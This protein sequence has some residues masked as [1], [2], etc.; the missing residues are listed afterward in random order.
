[1]NNV[2][3]WNSFP[4]KERN[5]G[6][7]TYLYNLSHGLSSL[8]NNNEINVVFLS[9]ILSDKSES[10][11][12]KKSINLFK[13]FLPKILSNNLRILNYLTQLRKFK[14]ELSV[15]QINKFK[16]IHFHQSIDIYKNR[17]ILK[18]FKGKVFLTSHSPKPAWMETIEDIYNLPL[19]KTFPTLRIILE[20]M[21]IWGFKKAD[22]LIFPCSEAIEPYLNWERYK[23]EIHILSKYKYLQTGIPK[24]SFKRDRVSIRKELNIPEN[25]I[26][27]S[28]IGRHSAIKGYDLLLELGK[29]ILKT[30]PNV[31]FLIAG[32]EEPI[33]GL[34]HK[35]WIEVGWTDDPHSYV[36]ASDVFILPNR[37]TYFDLV[38][39]EILSI[40]K[41]I[42]LS[43]TGGNKH[44]NKYLNSGIFFFEN[45]NLGSLEKTVLESIFQS[46]NHNSFGEL[47]K[48]IYLENYSLSA[49][50]S[51]Y[52]ELYKSL[53]EYN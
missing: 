30:H 15:D 40:G 29:L 53:V 43:E 2:L 24:A 46:K 3:I 36:N 14:P 19:N 22:I 18:Y 39:L 13:N 45:N 34:N 48:S 42:I 41:T 32:K 35:N 25:A 44:F 6:P 33:K 26:V 17:K 52:V 50:T 1:M 7:P 11:Q 28:F 38:L 12:V 8:E 16:A 20:D 23:N 4:L 9:D 27:F 47:N 21:D 31:F 37:Q 10:L 49:F 51:S 5:G